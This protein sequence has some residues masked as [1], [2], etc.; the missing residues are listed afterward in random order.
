MACGALPAGYNAN[1]HGIAPHGQNH[2]TLSAVA[3]ND[4]AH[5]VR[6]FCGIG[7]SVFLSMP[8]F[9]PEPSGGVRGRAA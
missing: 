4:F 1:G 5:G 3:Y 9:A 2:T 8:L 6:P 7:T